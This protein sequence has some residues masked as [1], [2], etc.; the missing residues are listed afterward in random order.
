MTEASPLATPSESIDPGGSLA[1]RCPMPLV[2]RRWI[3]RRRLM[4]TMTSVMAVVAS[5]LLTYGVLA[6][7]SCEVTSASGTHR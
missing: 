3:R 7:Q 1:A 5:A 2:G 6:V 4:R